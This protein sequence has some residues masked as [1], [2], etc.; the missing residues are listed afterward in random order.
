MSVGIN[1]KKR[2]FELKMTQQELAAA[3]GYKTRST[4]AKIEAGE[5]DVSQKKLRQFAL[6]LDT[7][8]DEFLIGSVFLK[9][10]EW[11]DVA[12]LLRN[13]NPTK[14]T[15]ARSFLIWMNDHVF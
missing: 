14:L 8:P 4:I 15:L 6:A 3:M 13:M 11:R 2:R 9:S 1:I 7:T 5:N 12:E 10:D